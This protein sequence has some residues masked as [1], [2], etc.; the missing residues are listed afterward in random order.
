M[1]DSGSTKD[2][3][4]TRILLPDE[5]F[6]L[7][8]GKY[9]RGIDVI[10]DE[11]W[12]K[13]VWL[14]DDVILRTSE[15]QGTQLAQLQ[16]MWEFWVLKLPLES[17]KAPFMFNAVW[18]AADDFHVS[19]FNAAHGFY[20]QAI[21]SLRN[22]IESM[23]IAAGYAVRNDT[24]NLRRWMNGD[25]EPKYGNGRD[26]LKPSVDVQVIDALEKVWEE[27]CSFNHAEVATTN[28]A[29]WQS[30]GPV[31][32]PAAFTRFYATFRDTM[33]LS[34]ILLAIG[35]PNF[36]IPKECDGLF[37]QPAQALVHIDDV[38]LARWR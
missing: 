31:W 17:S 1:I 33:A 35:W 19:T 34:Y 15:N 32:V 16:D 3:R 36:R 22:T 23:T 6:A 28:G 27:L 2:I 13:L 30:N 24:R 29:I 10:P 20:R 5:S 37:Q 14:S 12:R 18:D 25:I 7:V 38:I 4:T 11:Q 26:F 21:G 9:Q 8:K